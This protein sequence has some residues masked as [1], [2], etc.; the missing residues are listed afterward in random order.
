MMTKE[1]APGGSGEGYRSPLPSGSSRVLV[2]VTAFLG[3]FFAGTHLSITSLAMESAAID[4]LDRCGWIDQARHR[5]ASRDKV[6]TETFEAERV[7]IARWFAW[8]QCAL[9][10][11]AATGGLV[12]GWIGDR[13]GR[14]TGL[15]WSILT[16]SLFAAAAAY[17]QK[18]WQLLV[19][20]F[21]AC[22]GVGGTWP[23]AVALV[24]EVWSDLSR[25]FVAGFLGASANIA[26]FGMSALAS[27]LAIRSEN[28]RWVMIPASVPV[29]LGVLVLVTV[30]ESPLWLSRKNAPRV[31]FWQERDS[32]LSHSTPSPRP[33]TSADRPA[34]FRMP[35]LPV[36]LLAIV[37]ATVP[38]IGAWGSA[39]WMVPWASQAGEAADPPNPYLKANLLATRS[40][41]GVIGSALGGWIAAVVGRRLSYCL[42]SMGALVCAQ[43]TFWTLTP[44]DATFL[45]WV[46]ALGFFSGIYFGWLPLFLPELFPTAAR[47][48]G[49]GVGFNFGRILTAGTIA[50]T[51]IMMALFAGDYAK[52]GRVTSLVFVL[53]AL[54]VWAAPDTTRRKL[55]DS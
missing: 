52:I 15:G 8:Y 9:L 18:P 5:A 35:L 47:S 28:W 32:P 14:V 39:N 50:L 40:L 20:W 26:I 10:F 4:L 45:V 33:T 12:F 11:G 3:W 53:G 44:T 17:S 54:M 22:T 30:P 1:D 31:R 41:T 7:T 16:Y 29:V 46:G 38:L 51:G 24:S 19:L 43:W 37:L 21:M 23:N 42:I 36:T 2:L 49:A 55:T 25:P 27:Y 13:Y 48:T 6:R 34:V